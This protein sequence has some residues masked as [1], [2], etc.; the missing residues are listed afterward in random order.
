MIFSLFLMYQGSHPLIVAAFELK[1]VKLK[2]FSARW[3]VITHVQRTVTP[4]RMN[5]KCLRLFFRLFKLPCCLAAI[6]AASV[7]RRR[8]STTFVPQAKT[9]QQ[10]FQS[11]TKDRKKNHFDLWQISYNFE[12][13][14][15]HEQE[16]RLRFGFMLCWAEM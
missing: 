14:V 6:G 8:I 9:F 7:V 12:N 4:C 3:I 13:E 1:T 11:L 15:P 16:K 5:I 2:M 10:S